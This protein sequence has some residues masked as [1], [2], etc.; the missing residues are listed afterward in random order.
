M[1]E[2]LTAELER[3]VRYLH[4]MQVDKEKSLNH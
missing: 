3:N 2:E 1:E 4:E